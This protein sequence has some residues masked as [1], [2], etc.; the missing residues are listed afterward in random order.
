MV[1]GFRFGQSGYALRFMV[2]QCDFTIRIGHHDSAD[3]LVEQ[4]V[5]A[6]F[7]VLHLGV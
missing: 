7:A 2:D 6:D 5:I 1:K 4:N 3:Q